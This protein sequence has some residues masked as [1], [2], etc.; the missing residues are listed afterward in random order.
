M[1]LSAIAAWAVFL[2]ACGALANCAPDK[3]A[4]SMAELART[5]SQRAEADDARFFKPYFD[6]SIKSDKQVKNVL[7]G[8]RKCNIAQT[9]AQKMI[10][11]SPTQV[12][13]NY[14]SPAH[15]QI[16]LRQVSGR[17]QLAKIGLCR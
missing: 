8:L 16:S 13:L 2:V 11:V 12:R 14:H 3:G 7:V 10:R 17:W 5:I 4:P 9:Y 6:A 15:L 1:K